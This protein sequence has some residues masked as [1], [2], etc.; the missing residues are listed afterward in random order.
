MVGGRSGGSGDGE[1]D[2]GD[3][4]H[5][6]GGWAGATQRRVERRRRWPRPRALF[7]EPPLL[8]GESDSAAT[9]GNRASAVAIS[10][11]AHCHAC[12]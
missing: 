7:L 2:Q 4:R 11:L 9:D 8:S 5:V 10:T 3:H 6:D 12:V 1:R